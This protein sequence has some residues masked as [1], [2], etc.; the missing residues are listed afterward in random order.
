MLENNEIYI[1]GKFIKSMLV[2][3]IND[4]VIK[5][6]ARVLRHPEVVRVIASYRAEESANVIIEAEEQIKKEQAEA[7]ANAF[8]ESLTEEQ[9]DELAEILKYEQRLKALK[10]GLDI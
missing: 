4:N 8:L 3:S 5:E 2:Y 10:S 6:L 7:I 1:G 9:E